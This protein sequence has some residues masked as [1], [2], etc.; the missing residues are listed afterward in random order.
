MI[1]RTDGVVRLGEIHKGMRKVTVESDAGEV[2]E[3]DLPRSVHVNV[4]DGERVRAGDPLIDGPINPHDML[5]VLGKEHLERYLVDKIQE[6]Y[7]SQSVA[8]NDKHIEVIV[9]QM[10]RSV[11]VES[12][13]DTDFLIDEQVDKSRFDGRTSGCAP[14]GSRRSA[15]RS[16]S[17]S[18]R[19]RSRPIASSRRRA[20]RRR[21]GCSPRRRSP[22]RSLSGAEGERDRHASSRRAPAWPSITTP[23]RRGGAGRRA[24][25]AAGLFLRVR[26]GD[27]ELPRLPLD[28]LEGDLD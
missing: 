1:T 18:R 7:R 12:V 21:R 13:G 19:H 3:Y 17:G 8:I 22:A 24:R 11:K 27:D 9:R 28:V 2:W 26:R 25:R 15:A 14:A 4:Q 6:V 20:S 5:H 16:C 10:L 23:S